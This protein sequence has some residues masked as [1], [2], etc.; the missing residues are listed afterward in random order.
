[1]NTFIKRL[2]SEIKKEKPHVKFGLSPFGIWRPGYPSSIRGMDQYDVLFADAKLWLNKGWIDYFTPQL[3]W[4][5]N[6][7]PQSFPVLLGWWTKENHK[8]RNLWP[9]LYL[10]K[11]NNEQGIYEITNQ[12]MISR[13]FNNNAPG[14]VHF[15][16][17]AFL[18]DSTEM[19]KSLLKSVYRKEALAP[20]SP[21]LENSPPKSPQLDTES[22]GDSLQ[23]K[24][25]HE[26]PEDVFRIV[27]Y[28]KYQDY[29]NYNIYNQSEY[30]CSIPKVFEFQDRKKNIIR[31]QLAEIAVSA[32]DRLGNERNLKRIIIQ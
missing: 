22:I 12:I 24:W 4:P 16:A 20:S 31:L 13:G 9:G 30:N 21:W 15:S 6:Q 28:F 2:Y 1:V 26:N 32:V 3:Y 17:K 10:S 18:V 5:I 14:H 8:S 27:V 7:V 29:W 23:I 19:K 25:S 11:F